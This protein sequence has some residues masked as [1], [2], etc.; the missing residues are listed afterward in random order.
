V[1]LDRYANLLMA[2][3]AATRL[4]GALIDP[5]LL[6]SPPNLLR[7][8]FHPQ[9][10]R[11]AI[12]N[13]DLVARHLSARAQRE[14]G[15]YGDDPT[16]VELLTELRGYLEPSAPIAAHAHAADLLLPVQ[17]RIGDDELQMFSTIMT[18]G[19]PQDVTPRSFDRNVFS[20]RRGI[21]SVSSAAG[22][23]LTRH[24]LHLAGVLFFLSGACA[25]VYQVVWLRMLSLV[26]GVTVY[27][28]SAVLSTFM[29]GLALGAWLGGRLADRVSSRSL[30]S[31]C[32]SSALARWRSWCPWRF[33]ASNRSTR[34]PRA[35]S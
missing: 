11:R 15:E 12:V 8:V 26:F 17:L 6:A 24:E 10:L 3:A 32:S 14:L 19:T 16:A 34:C 1:V 33:V 29:G 25:L 35:V 18:M 22:I 4:F 9:G 2:N 13:W 5:A 7:L 21:R 31:R 30:R 27:A 20:G 28:A 23:A